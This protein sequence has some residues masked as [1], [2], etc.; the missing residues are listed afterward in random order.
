MP[1]EEELLATIDA[2]PDDDAPRLAHADWLENNGDRERAE[3]IRAQLDD[4]EVDGSAYTD[5]LPRVPGMKWDCRRGHPEQV[6]FDSVTAFKKGWPLTRGRRVR[7]VIFNE[8]RSGKAL[9]SLPAL[10]EI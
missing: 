1:T 5:G 2:S 3:F 8:L 10:A 9:A 6:T 4:E 7:H